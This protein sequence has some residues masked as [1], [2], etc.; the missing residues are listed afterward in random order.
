MTAAPDLLHIVQ[1]RSTGTVPHRVLGI[2]RRLLVYAMQRVHDERAPILQ[3]G[4]A[5]LP[6]G[7]GQVVERIE[8]EGGCDGY[9]DTVFGALLVD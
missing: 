4:P 8:V 5:D 6:A 7:A 3:Q 9:G 1:I 2:D